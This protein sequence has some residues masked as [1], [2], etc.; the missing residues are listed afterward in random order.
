M[1]DATTIATLRQTARLPN[2]I[3]REARAVLKAFGVALQPEACAPSREIA[4]ER[5]RHEAGVSTEKNVPSPMPAWRARLVVAAHE[6]IAF[7]RQA[8][9]MTIIVLAASA[10][11]AWWLLLSR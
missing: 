11:P 3:G 1:L 2:T 6:Y 9:R 7:M 5:A 4:S 10:I 8:I